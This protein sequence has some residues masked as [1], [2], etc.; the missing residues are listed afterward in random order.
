MD[1]TKWIEEISN[2]FQKAKIVDLSPTL[3]NNM[4]R[5]PTH[6]PIVINQTITHKHD[7][8]YC[9]TLFIPEH[10]GAHVDA[11]F[12]VHPNLTNL[13]VE[14]L[15]MKA[16]IGPAKV[17][18]LTSFNL[19]PGEYA[20]IEHINFLEKKKGFKIAKDDILLIN[21]GWMKKTWTNGSEW[22]TYAGNSPGLDKSVAEYFVEK[23]IKAVG[24]D[25]IACGTASK[26][27]QSDFCWIHNLLLPRNIYLMECLA[28]LD[29]LPLNVFFIAFPLKI[30]NGS[31]SP[32]RPVALI[33]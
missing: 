8:Y 16:L 32:I 27:C 17:L 7:G 20:T 13:T 22:K 12:H 4:P 30:I 6:P 25:T 21:F 28:N 11:P 5:F 9:Q 1:Y 2:F 23:E 19:A 3:E 18:D 29:I 26:D 15:P 14:T 33:Y 24:S 31:G 10:I